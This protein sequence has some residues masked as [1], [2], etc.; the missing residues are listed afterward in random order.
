MMAAFCVGRSTPKEGHVVD[1]CGQYG[2][3]EFRKSSFRTHEGGRT[4]VL[5]LW[6]LSVHLHWGHIAV[7]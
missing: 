4:H 5:D 7:T 2:S 6:G 1:R 3:H